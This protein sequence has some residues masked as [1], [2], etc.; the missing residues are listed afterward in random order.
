MSTATLRRCEREAEGDVCR[1]PPGRPA[2]S[3]DEHKQ[4]RRVIQQ[5]LEQMGWSAGEGAVYH[6]LDGEIS[7]RLVRAALRSLKAERRA[8]ITRRAKRERTTIEVVA[9]DALCLGDRVK[10]GQL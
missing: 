1:R 10:T 3:Q 8:R 5:A 9:R 7:M 4:A 6:E 2:R